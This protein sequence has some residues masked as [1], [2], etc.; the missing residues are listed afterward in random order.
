MPRYALHLEY[1]GATFVGWQRQVAG[2]SV[3]QV[4]EEAAA[5]LNRGEP[6]L[7]TAAGRTD[8]GVHAECQVADL[9]LALDLPPERVRDAINSR[10]LP[11]PVVVVAAARVAE[12]WSARFSCIGRAYRYRILNR[13]SR[14]ALEM[15][16]AWHVKRRLDAGAM[17]E[18][19]QAL[20][21]RHDFSAFRAA[22]CQAKSALRTLDR[23]D[24][25]RLGEEVVFTVE[26]RSFLHHQVRNLVGT[27]AEVGL[28]R[29]PVTWPRALLDGR[30]RRRSGQTAPPDGLVLTR[31]RYAPEP[32]WT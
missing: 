27:L 11:H 26:A 20:L 18:A 16:R 6:P 3:Q 28:G 15:R 2:L 14:P 10:T 31:A 4:L 9:H 13:P 22:S 29:R 12:D 17:H 24:V 30:D 21:G 5:P 8:A 7:A 25:A 23:L 19:A 1:D 32:D